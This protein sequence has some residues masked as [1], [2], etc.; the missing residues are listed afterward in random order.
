MNISK[1]SF[2]FVLGLPNSGAKFV[3]DS[4][5]GA[6]FIM[7]MFHLSEVPH[8]MFFGEKLKCTECLSDQELF[9]CFMQIAISCFLCSFG[10]D[11]LD[12]KY[13]RQLGDFEQAN[14]LDIFSS[15]QSSYPWN[16]KSLEVYKS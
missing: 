13:I 11:R 10:N 15:L 16:Y 8:I 6:D 14:R 5:G 1:D 9:V 2:H 7:S 4:D 12:T 3:D